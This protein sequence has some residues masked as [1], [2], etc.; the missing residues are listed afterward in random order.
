MAFSPLKTLRDAKAR[1]E[2]LAMVS[3]YD[4]PT[5][6][7][8]CEAGVD[9]ILVGDSMGNAI[10]GYEDFLSVTMEDMVRH[11]AA[12]AR[13]VKSSA[14]PGVPVVAD[15][16]FGSYATVAEA[17]ENGAALVR[18]GGRAI[19]L[20]GAGPAALAAVR[21]L[22]EMG[23]PVVGHLGFT[24]QSSLRFSGVVQGKTVEAAERMLEGAREL[25]EAG[26]DALVLEAVP[27][28]VAEGIT[29]ALRI[30]TI[31]IGS[32]AGCDGQVLVWHDLVGLTPGKPFRFVKLYAEAGQYLREATAGFVR[33]VHSGAFPAPEHGWEM[34]EA[35]LREWRGRSAEGARRSHDG[36]DASGG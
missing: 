5:A 12:V 29:R 31:G 3:L 17:A 22:V 30:P 14:R 18:A 34:P 6:A 13:G 11:T 26:C 8:A 2:K 36:T 9:V 25:E 7:L 23:A 33:D 4:A 1:G 15:L 20:E 35:E 32:G 16:P 10:L 21:T 27:A 19:K 24:P 28:E